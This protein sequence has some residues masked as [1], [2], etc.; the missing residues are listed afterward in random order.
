VLVLAAACGAPA[1]PFDAK[2]PD[3]PFVDQYNPAGKDASYD[4]SEY[5]GPAVLAGIAKTRG[6]TGGLQDAAL[7]SLLAEV[8]GTNDYGTSGNGMIAALEWLGL[9][10]DAREGDDL[11]WIDNE[12]AAGHD[13]IAN[14]DYYSLPNHADPNLVSG[15]YIAVTG[16]RHDWS[17]YE[18]MDPAGSSLHSLTDSQLQA[19]IEAHPQGG[20]TIS[21]W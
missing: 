10:T 16:V 5:C 2:A 11:E 19:F 14:G 13:V 8:A 6:Q 1:E 4:G 18:V 12:L 7:V 21:A 3:V 9:Q 20:F 17:V 15:H